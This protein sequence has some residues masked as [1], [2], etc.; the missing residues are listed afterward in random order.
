MFSS[1]IQKKIKSLP[2]NTIIG[3]KDTTITEKYNIY[4]KIIDETPFI[5]PSSFNGVEIWGNKL[6]KVFTQ[7]NCG[8][9]WAFASNSTLSDRFNIQSLGKLSIQLSP[10]KMLLCSNVDLHDITTDS[11]NNKIQSKEVE[12]VDNFACFGNTLIE[13]CNYLYVYG[14]NTTDC[15]SYNNFGNTNKFQSLINFNDYSKLPLCSTISGPNLDMCDDRI[16]LNSVNEIIGK[17]ARFYRSFSLYGIYG[18]TLYHKKGSEKQIRIEIYQWGPV[19]TAFEIYPDFYTFDPKTEIYEW[20]GK[21]DKISGHAVEIVGW[22]EENGK[23]YWQIKN[24]W[25]GNWGQN[26]YFKMVRGNN[27]CKIEENCIGMM[28]DFFYS[29]DY[30]K[31]QVVDTEILIEKDK[32][33]TDTKRNLF[34]NDVSK[35]GGIV[36]TTGYSKRIMNT[37]PWLNLKRP[38][39]LSNLPNWDT[40]IAGNSLSLPDTIKYSEFNKNNTYKITC[41]D[42]ISYIFMFLVS[43]LIIAILLLL[44]VIVLRILK[45]VK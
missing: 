12:T 45:K 38:I 2:T 16:T 23:K 30:N 27:N 33:K 25:G 9:C 40:F 39:E 31:K 32:N 13:A 35:G 29:T 43:I 17:P 7:G 5:L 21:G 34:I 1:E 11:G 15:I 44:F 42:Q 4:K 8:S 19:C 10:T 41:D 28:P 3:E 24:S 37:Y 26:G 6:S 36:P 14:S 18:S 22:G 20:N